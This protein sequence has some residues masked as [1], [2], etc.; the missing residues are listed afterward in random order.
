MIRLFRPNKNF[1]ELYHVSDVSNPQ[2][3]VLSDKVHCEQIKNKIS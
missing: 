2:P 1:F 3:D